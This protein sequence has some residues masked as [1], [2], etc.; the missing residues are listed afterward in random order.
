MSPLYVQNVIKV[1][2]PSHE[3]FKNPSLIFQHFRYRGAGSVSDDELEA[4]RKRSRE[5]YERYEKQKRDARRAQARI[6]RHQPHVKYRTYQKSATRR[7]LAFTLTKQQCVDMFVAPC[8][9][10]KREPK[11]PL[12][13]GIDRVDN[14]EGYTP[15]NTVPCCSRC[16]YMKHK[17]DY[18][19]FLEQCQAIADAQHPA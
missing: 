2:D 4:Q 10:C 18:D 15:D 3:F 12:T 16:N 19:S 1:T 17:Y 7:H 11:A 14:D 9:Y 6:Y 13:H 5:A 8:D